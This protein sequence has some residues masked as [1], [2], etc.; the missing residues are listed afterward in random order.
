MFG[1]A[2]GKLRDGCRAVVTFSTTIAV[3]NLPIAYQSL[4]GTLE[5]VAASAPKAEGEDTFDGIYDIPVLKER[6]PSSS[7]PSQSRTPTCWRMQCTINS[8]VS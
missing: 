1:N 2:E 8:K 3:G 4:D 7:R 6:S 5:E